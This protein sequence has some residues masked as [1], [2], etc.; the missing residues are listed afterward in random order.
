MKKKLGQKMEICENSK[1]E[2]KY[3]RT[4]KMKT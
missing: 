1:F 3:F 2:K 4:K